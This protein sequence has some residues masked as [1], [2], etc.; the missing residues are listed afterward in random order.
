MNL[1]FEF[2]TLAFCEKC[3][4]SK[5]Q[6]QE[7]D[8]SLKNQIFNSFKNSSFIKLN[9]LCQIKKGKQLNKSDM[10]NNGE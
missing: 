6:Y 3:M 8:L 7:L 1:I 2:F 9:D 5:L 10:E 4:N